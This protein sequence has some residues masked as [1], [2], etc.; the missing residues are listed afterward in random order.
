MRNVNNWAASGAHQPAVNPLFVLC[1][2][3]LF[4]SPCAAIELRGLHR[5][6]HFGELRVELLGRQ[7]V[8]GVISRWI[9]PRPSELAL[10]RQRLDL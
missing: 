5:G 6:L 10:H 2:L 3:F 4:A 8:L 9:F 7:V 1:A